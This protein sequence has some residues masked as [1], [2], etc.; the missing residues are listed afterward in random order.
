ME[1][2]CFWMKLHTDDL[3]VRLTGIHF[4]LHVGRVQN[5]GVVQ[6]RR[7]QSHWFRFQV[8]TFTFLVT[9]QSTEVCKDTV[10]NAILKFRF[11]DFLVGVL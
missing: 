7:L 8:A 5:R 3:T 9:N 11:E 10:W 2:S 6:N 1:H 4:T